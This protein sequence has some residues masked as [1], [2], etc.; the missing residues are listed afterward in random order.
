M[1]T[2]KYTQEEIIAALQESGGMISAASRAL[3]CTPKTIYNYA[4]DNE[5]IQAAL[6]YHR[7]VILDL[8]EQKVTA[9]VKKGDPWAVKL[10][11]TTLGIKR[12]YGQSITL[13]TGSLPLIQVEYVHSSQLPDETQE[14]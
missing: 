14:D 9:A 7:E 10:V 3:G 6:D 13:D 5:E 1:N 4:R 8:A 11:L 2:K 12:G